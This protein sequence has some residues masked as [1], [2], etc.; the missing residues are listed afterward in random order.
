MNSHRT[1]VLSGL[2]LALALLCVAPLAAA[3]SAY[4]EPIDPAGV[5]LQPQE[6]NGIPYLKGGIGLDESRAMQQTRGYNL[7][8]TLSSG[9]DNKYQSGAEVRVETATGQPVLTLQDIGPML[10]AKLPNG[11]YQVLASLNGQQQRQQVVI[12]GSKPVKVNLHWRE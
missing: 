1:H 4:Q 6:Q 5:Q 2:G 10:F 3:Q 9:T 12:D 8:I 7:E 11:H